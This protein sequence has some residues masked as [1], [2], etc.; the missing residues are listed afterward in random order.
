VTPNLKTLIDLLRWRAKHQPNRVSYTFLVD[1]ETEEDTLTYGELDRQARAIAAGLHTLVSPGERVLLLYPPGLEYI[2]AF[3]G[4]LYAGAVAVPAYPPRR[5]RNLLRLQAVV[6]D[7]QATVALTNAS[8]LTRI[9]P[10]FSQYPYLAPLRWLTSDSVAEG[11]ENDWQEPVITGEALAF[12]QYTSGSTSAPKGVMLSH[13][14]LLHNERLI[15]KVFRQNEDSIIAGWLPL[16][17]DM[18]LIGNVIQPLFIGAPCVLMSPTTFLQRPF[19]WLQA[20]SRYRATTSGGPNFA[21]DLCVRKI[22]AEQRA[23]LDLSNW[24]VAFNGSEPVRF[25]TIESFATTFE[26]CGFRREAF[27]PCYGLAEAT[28]LV[29]GSLKDEAPIYTKVQSRALEFNRVV[30]AADSDNDSVRRMVSC[31][32]I[33][34]E[35]QVVIVHPDT[36]SRCQPQEVGEIW[37]A[38]E[39][40]ARG[41]WNRAEDTERAFNAH[42]VETGTGPFLRT[43][44]LGVVFYER[45]VSRTNFS[46]A[47]SIR[48]LLRPTSPQPDH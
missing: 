7:A 33:L 1:G 41:Y 23:T 31:G 30:E 34:P 17:H 20:I 12:L 39:S 29:S 18:G 14:N 28:L 24:R 10:F 5:N 32:E 43:G 9:V 21:Y 22:S 15:Q 16:Y 40:V 37:V 36:L 44:D 25:D 47:G 13:G 11:M 4:C 27:H 19:R 35:Q 38:G 3:F 42:L 48:D 26:T 46:H 8:I 2:A 6:A 45:G